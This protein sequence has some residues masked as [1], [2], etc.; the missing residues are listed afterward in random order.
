MHT[1]QLNSFTATGAAQQKLTEYL[2]VLMQTNHL[3][4]DAKATAAFCHITNR[5]FDLMNSKHVFEGLKTTS[6]PRLEE[7][8]EA[9]TCILYSRMKLVHKILN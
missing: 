6:Q 1:A 8:K 2:Q 9:S 3:H 4:H 5:W 7:L